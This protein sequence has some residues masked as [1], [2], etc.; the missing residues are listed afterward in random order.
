MKNVF[1]YKIRKNVS[2]SRAYINCKDVN[3]GN[4]VK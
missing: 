4:N 1:D 2:T 3:I